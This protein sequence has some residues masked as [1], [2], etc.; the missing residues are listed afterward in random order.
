[1]EGNNQGPKPNEGKSV[2]RMLN[3]I[4]IKELRNYFKKKHC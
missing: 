3:R 4:T 1:M 2:D